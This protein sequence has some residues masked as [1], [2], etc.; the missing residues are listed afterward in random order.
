MDKFHLTADEAM[1]RSTL[2]AE[3]AFQLINKS[4]TETH[5]FVAALSQ[6]SLAYS[7]LLPYLQGPVKEILP[8]PNNK[9]IL[10]GDTP[11]G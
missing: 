9:D 5:P 1:R 11:F 4:I 7:A 2:A 10:F 8:D 3:S 6:L